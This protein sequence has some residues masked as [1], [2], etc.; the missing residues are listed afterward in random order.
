MN[1][2]ECGQQH[3]TDPDASIGKVLGSCGNAWIAEA[4]QM[5]DDLRNSY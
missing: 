2:P 3:T 1:C 4:E 5:A